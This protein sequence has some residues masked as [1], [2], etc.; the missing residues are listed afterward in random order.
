MHC[1]Y[2]DALLTEWESKS[3]D[4][5]DRSSFLDLCSEC[6]QWSTASKRT[7]DSLSEVDS[8]EDLFSGPTDNL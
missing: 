7:I 6:R 5:K 1:K 4:P 2:C 8:L 3:K